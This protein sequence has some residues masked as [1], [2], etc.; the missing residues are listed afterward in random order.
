[1]LVN[2]KKKGE[3]MKIAKPQVSQGLEPIGGG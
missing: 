2:K 1:M 3:N